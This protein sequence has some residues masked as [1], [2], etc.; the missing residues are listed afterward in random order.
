MTVKLKTGQNIRR[1]I[2]TI[3]VNPYAINV[4]IVHLESPNPS[5]QFLTLLLFATD[6]PEVAKRNSCPKI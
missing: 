5:T 4:L 6:M 2:L 3:N 1:A